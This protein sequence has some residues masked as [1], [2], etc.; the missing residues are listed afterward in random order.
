MSP[1]SHQT[2]LQD[3]RASPPEKP[4]LVQIMLTGRD[5]ETGLGMS[6]QSIKGNVRKTLCTGSSQLIL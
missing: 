4:D 1:P 2:V 6:D 5:T 3:H